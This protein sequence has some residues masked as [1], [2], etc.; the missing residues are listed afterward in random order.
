MATS[1]PEYIFTAID[2]LWAVTNDVIV[3][4][5]GCQ[6]DVQQV[7][8]AL[9]QVTLDGALDVLILARNNRGTGAMKI[10]RSMLEVSLTAQYL[11]NNPKESI[12]YQEFAYILAWRWAQSSPGQY[13][14]EQRQQVDAE[15]NRVRAQFTN[16]KGRVQNTWSVK[17]IKQMA[18]EIGRTDIYEVMYG[19]ASALHHVNALGLLGHEL[20]FRRAGCH[21][22]AL[23]FVRAVMSCGRDP[24]HF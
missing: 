2:T 15:Y 7:I 10:A 22:H 21:A 6:D 5:E 3:A 9:T 1:A 24:L 19:A 4:T 8:R 12:A 17:S 13:T 23:A 20:V 18:D 14:A 16:S 11:E